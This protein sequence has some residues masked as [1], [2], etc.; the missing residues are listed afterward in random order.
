MIFNKEKHAIDWIFRYG[1]YAI[2]KLEK[3]LL[4]HLIGYSYISVFHNMDSKW[5]HSYECATL[6]KETLEIIYYSP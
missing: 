1:N 3:I 4:N 5:L 2:S 6:Y